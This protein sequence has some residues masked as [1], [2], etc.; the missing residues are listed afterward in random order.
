MTEIASIESWDETFLGLA[1][2]MER[3]AKYLW[4]SHAEENAVARAAR[5]GVSLKVCTAKIQQG[6]PV[7]STRN[8]ESL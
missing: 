4:T 8:Y 7:R 1:D 3:S 2:R 6:T 5:I